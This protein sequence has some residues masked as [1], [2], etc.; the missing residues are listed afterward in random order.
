M[1][2]IASTDVT[3]V[4]SW[5]LPRMGRYVLYYRILDIALSGNGGTAADI[6]ATTLGFKEILVA[7][8]LRYTVTSGGALKHVPVIVE[9]SGAGLLTIN[10]ADATDATR[11]APANVVS[12]GTLRVLVCGIENS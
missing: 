4:S 9:A 7:T 1:A 6:P 3:D 10:L 2:A 11:S 5:R 8:P 12:A